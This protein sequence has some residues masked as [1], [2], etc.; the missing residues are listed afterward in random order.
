[1]NKRITSKELAKLAG[2]SAATISR[3]FSE[4]TRISSATRRR[5]LA[6]AEEHNYR[7]NA[8]ARSLNRQRSH[9]VALV[10]NSI[11]NPCEAEQLQYLVQQLQ[12]R[13]L[14]PIIL[15]CDGYDDR[16]QLMRM[17]SAYQV[18]HVVLFSDA[19]PMKD[20]TQIFRS[21]RPIV[22]SFEPVSSES[23][24]HIE[25]DGSK[26]AE[27]LIS[28]A[29]GAGRSR[30][31]YLAGRKTSWIDKRRKRWFAD[32]LAAHDL[33]FEA[34]WHGDYSYESG[35]KEAVVM[36]RRS[37]IDAVV[38]GNDVMAI[39]VRDAAVHVLGKRV[40]EELAIIGQDGIAMAA[41]ESH[42]LTTLALDN[43]EFVDAI[44]Q[45]IE[46]DAAEDS[47]PAAK[48]LICKVRW[49]STC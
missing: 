36:L 44:V 6:I 48:T 30:F 33:T 21:A 7:P 35:F 38:C 15:C 5:I 9:L 13:E 8:I 41:W 2:V 45:A 22:L 40:P 3:A 32:A 46:K 1:M 28:K 11:S 19:V 49:G 24:S 16:A 31:A 42:D 29:V 43:V 25:V 37:K 12:Q 47:A 18:D 4:E 10:V 23:V 39:G 34:E 17:A 27:E 20:A 26:A 14:M